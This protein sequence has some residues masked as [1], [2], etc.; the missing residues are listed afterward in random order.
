MFKYI[1]FGIL[2]GFFSLWGYVGAAIVGHEAGQTMAL[3]LTLAYVGVI[4]FL[5]FKDKP[6]DFAYVLI[7]PMFIV[8]GMHIIY[9]TVSYSIW[10]WALIMKLLQ[11]NAVKLK[12]NI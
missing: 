8:I 9:S 5:I 6:E 4:C 2:S 1:L 11:L 12:L 7:L 10:R 3:L